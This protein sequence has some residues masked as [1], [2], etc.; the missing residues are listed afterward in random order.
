VANN[1]GGKFKTVSDKEFVP[2]QY[3]IAVKKGNAELLAKLDK[4]LADIKADGTY[5]EIYK[6]YFGAA[7]AKAA[8]AP[9]SAAS[10]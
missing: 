6:K 10:K 3:G 8:A 4:G 1:P 9:A 2:E 5:D 7:P